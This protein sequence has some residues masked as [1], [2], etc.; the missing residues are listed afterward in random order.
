MAGIIPVPSKLVTMG[1]G[2]MPGFIPV[3]SKLVTTGWGVMAGQ[4]E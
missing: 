1:W 3:P 2:V 4:T